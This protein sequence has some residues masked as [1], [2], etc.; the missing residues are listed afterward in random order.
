M[1]TYCSA[2]EVLSG[3]K[4][5]SLTLSNLLDLIGPLT[6]NLDG[7]LDGLGTSVHGQDHVVAESAAHLGSPDGEDVIVE[8]ARAQGQPTSLLS[9]GLD[10]LGMTVALVDGAV[11]REEVEVVVALGIP[12]VH[13]LGPR[14]H[15]GQWVVVVRR[16]L[17]FIVDRARC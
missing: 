5:K 10:Q 6:S 3:S 13:A 17:E 9:E 2:M 16:I 7:S 8:S 11:G 1:G 4:D 12:D 14:K 15:D